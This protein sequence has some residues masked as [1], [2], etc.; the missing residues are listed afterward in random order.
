M[1]KSLKVKEV[2]DSDRALTTTP[3]KFR[4]FRLDFARLATWKNP[5]IGVDP[6]QRH[7][8]M[9]HLFSDTA[10]LAWEIE[11]ES[12]DTPLRRVIET[13]HLMNHLL[14]AYF[15]PGLKT[16]AVVEN[17]AFGAPFG[18]VPLA[19]NRAAVIM[20]LHE[21]GIDDILTIP[22]QSIRKE[23]FGSAKIRAEETWKE[24]LPGNAAS[25]LACALYGLKKGAV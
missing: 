1:L 8:G 22:P 9:T 15:Q 5:I 20:E 14:H 4:T 21:F 3:F 24:F 12:F 16:L 18:Q 10:G 13:A 23:V 6:G 11:F 19:E 25:S 17:A 7:M 2:V